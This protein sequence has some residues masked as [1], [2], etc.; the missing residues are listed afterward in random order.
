MTSLSGLYIDETF[1]RLVQ[2]DATRTQFADGLGNSI[3]FGQTPTGSL[4]LTASAVGNTITFTKGDGSQFPVTVSGGSGTPGGPNTSIQFNKNGAFSGSSALTF[5]SAS[6]ALTLSGSLTVTGS[7]IFNS[8]SQ[9]TSTYYGNNYPGYID[10]VAGAPDGFVEL[11]SY[12]QS[13]S[14][15]VD[16]YSVY[17]TT[18]SSS[19][20]NLWEFKN[21][22][23]LLAPRGI[24]ALSFTG[25]LF[26]TASW[27][28]NAVTAS[29]IT[30]SFFTGTNAALSASYA[31]T[32][33]YVVTAQTASYVTSSNI[34]GTVLSSSYAQT[35]SYATTASYVSSNFQ[36]E[37]HVSQVDGND[38]TGDGSLLKPVA[39]ITKGL[40]LVGSQRKTIIVH[41]GTYTESPSI[42]IQYTT[43]TGPGLIGG[44]IVIAGTVS[45]NNGCT[46]SG[47]KMTNLTITTPAGAG[48]VNILNCEISGTLTKSSNADYTV[49]RLCDYGAA[50]ITGAGLIAIFGGNPN[51]TTVNNASANVIIKSAVTVAPVLTAGTLNLVDSIV[52][53]AAV[54]NAFTSAAGTV[55]TLANSQFLTSALNNVAPVVLNG[56]YSILN[57]V[58]DKPTS[59][60][61]ALSA[62]GGSTNSVDYFQYI[63][64]D[65]I[66]TK[67]VT[68]SGS[69]TI[70]GSSPF[71]NIGPAVFSGSVISTQGFSGSFSGSLTGT[72]TTASYVLQAVSA[73]FASNGG[74]T[75]L[76]P[77]INITLSPTNGLGQVTINSTGGGSNFNT[78][79]G[80][81]GSF[82]STQTQTNVAGTARSMSLNVTDI[83]NGVSISG[84]TNPFNT[85]IKT[86]NA[87]V[88]NIQ[89]SAQI[90]KTDSG[91]DNVYV[92]V[93]KNES[94]L[95]DTATSVTLVG[96]SAQYVAAWN[97]FVNAAAN[98]YFQLMW[99]STDANIRLHAEPA[100]GVVPGIPSLIV[101]A[102]RVDQFLSN[103]GSFS[104]SFTG[105]LIG[106]ATT[107]S[108]IT[109]SFFTGINAA[110]SASYAT[111]ASYA[112]NIPSLKASSASVASF[113]GTPKS[114]SI[115]FASSFPNNS[116]AVTV[117]GEDAR[118][119]TI[120]SK[121]SA[122]FTINSNSTVA[123]TGPVYW[124]ATPFN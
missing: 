111:T 108:Y 48:N 34:V 32:A 14:V 105:N 124:I 23:R 94:D 5:N 77:G 16:D 103:T 116:Y 80:S 49:L 70:S 89:F 19:Q 93:R 79:T 121:T 1:P 52:V 107:A 114:S 42:T 92:W 101:T 68:I 53:A 120:Q 2:T 40:T 72:A 123:L 46:I 76:L 82:Y 41:P 122:G 95:S 96:N 117:T 26:G 39:T 44:N 63:D 99:Y 73:S 3:S 18:N 7:I 54:T 36:Y 86:A 20:F 33:S 90:D 64:A 91:T 27:A 112:A 97:F 60:L 17:I 69:L 35:A 102:N 115:T 75:Q 110:L 62:T 83:T 55:T 24:E 4:L 28:S 59:T 38:T 13:S 31:I 65:N 84:S 6:N 87:G 98:D 11:L 22:G 74:V 71:T 78:A 118:S 37:I 104:G 57:C 58:F 100:F 10:I 47:I 85:Y 51:F 109:S 45:T 56:F 12:N 21:D 43:I 88:Y 15:N 106:T 9:I 119:W 66:T 113:S 67:G 81:Y 30:S 29:Y 25:S 50:S 61:V 8:G